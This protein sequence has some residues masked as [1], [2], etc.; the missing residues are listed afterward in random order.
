MKKFLSIV[1]AV[2]IMCSTMY[3]LADGNSLLGDANSDGCINTSDAVAILRHTAGIDKLSGDKLISADVTHDNMVNTAD[4]VYVLRYVAGII[5]SFDESPSEPINSTYTFHSLEEYREFCAAGNLSD[6][7][8]DNY[9]RTHGYDISSKEQHKAVC[10]EINAAPLPMP[11]GLAFKY[12]IFHPDW[13]QLH[14]MYYGKGEDGCSFLI[15]TDSEIMLDEYLA[16]VRSKENVEKVELNNDCISESYYITEYGNDIEAY[17]VVIDGYFMLYR[18]ARC[19]TETAREYL[20]SV[21]V[22]SFII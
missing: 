11:D 19:T 18:A 4:A 9:M 14:V 3:A 15:N 17:Y 16:D 1:L 10:D 21:N 5:T 8:F 13:H 20:E 7:E 6:T 22:S 12:L 2:I